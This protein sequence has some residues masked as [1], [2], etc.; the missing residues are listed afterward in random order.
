MQV[1]QC[2]D[3]FCTVETGSVFREDAFSREVEKQLKKKKKKEQL[4]KKCLKNP[5][6]THINRSQHA[7]N[8][9]ICVLSSLPLAIKILTASTL[10]AQAG[11]KTLPCIACK[12]GYAI[13]CVPPCKVIVS[14]WRNKAGHQHRLED[15]GAS[16]SWRCCGSTAPW[17]MRERALGALDSCFMHAM[18]CCDVKRETGK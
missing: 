16:D 3:Y 13:A 1:L 10:P 15:N 7:A 9:V 5:T 11:G 14:G 6:E 18:A 12:R 17:V 2:R 8:A 4:I